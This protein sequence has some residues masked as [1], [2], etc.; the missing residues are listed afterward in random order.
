MT[1]AITKA[2]RGL[3]TRITDR[4]VKNRP[5]LSKIAIGLKIMPTDKKKMTMKVSFKG[6]DVTRIFCLKGVWEAAMPAM[7]APRA[8]DV[9]KT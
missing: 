6:A 9:P 5:N 7:K 3:I 4:I 8:I 2:R 1:V